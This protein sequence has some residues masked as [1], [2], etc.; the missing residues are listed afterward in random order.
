M[1]VVGAVGHGQ[2]R[3]PLVCACE[4]RTEQIAGAMRPSMGARKS[5]SAASASKPPRTRRGNGSLGSHRQPPAPDPPQT[6]FSNF[7]KVPHRGGR[8]AEMLRRPTADAATLLVAV[9]A[10]FAAPVGALRIAT[11]AAPRSLISCSMRDA[12]AQ[13][14]GGDPLPEAEIE[15]TVREALKGWSA[16]SAAIAVSGG[17]TSDFSADGGY[18]K[19]AAIRSRVDEAAPALEE[20]LRACA[21]SAP[22]LV[23]EPF[24]CL[25]LARL[26]TWIPREQWQRPLEDWEGPGAEADAATCI[27]SLRGHLLERWDTPPV[28]HDALSLTGDARASSVPE[29][30]H[31]ASFAFVSVL[32]A[33]G[34]GSA[35][36]KEALEI[37]ISGEPA[38]GSLPP[39]VSKAV[40][41]FV[42][43][44][45]AADA[46]AAGGNPVHLLRRAQV[47]AQGGEAWVGEGVCRSKMGGRLLGAGSDDASM[48]ADGLREGVS[49]AYGAALISWVCT[50]A[51]SLGE[52]SDVA[53]AID[54]AIEMRSAQ[55]R[56]YSLAGRTP[57]TVAAALE[58]YAIT[59]ITFDNDEIVRPPLSDSE[60][61][62]SIR[63]ACSDRA[64]RVCVCA[65][66]CVCVCPGLR[67]LSPTHTA[68]RGSLS[69][70]RP[71]Q[72]ARSS[73]SL[74]TIR[75]TAAPKVAT[76]LGQARRMDAVRARAPC[77]SR[78]W[79]PSG[80]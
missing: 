8:A 7:S 4:A 80:G 24:A 46:K 1:V 64:A 31:R 39:V 77:A 62:S 65:C 9:L 50:H 36:V 75:S 72:P 48:A 42:V 23:A 12:L 60:V 73:K 63:V 67:S 10:L 69:P 34:S 32:S 20:L 44:P 5:L 76:P 56:G 41:K 27:A 78:R 53:T 54:Y 47:A 16:M 49:E 13:F 6:N 58:A 57:K 30:A 74:T 40:A 51:E 79:A 17:G 43:T 68:S 59:T 61:C 71:S 38:D 18:P 2:P 28:L 22:A 14:L 66:V 52:V 70:I 21:E 26:A 25:P 35:S 3:A 15:P 19:Q 37:A 29:A 33:A 45:R 11:A 55:E